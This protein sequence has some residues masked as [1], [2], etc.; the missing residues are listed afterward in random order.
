MDING[1]DVK[2]LRSSIESVEKDPS[3]GHYTFSAMTTWRGGGPF[4]YRC[5][6]I[7]H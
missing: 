6:G 3:L 4:I 7:H 1:I 2:E 5:T